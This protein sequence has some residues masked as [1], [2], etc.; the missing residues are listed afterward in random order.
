MDWAKLF[1]G[2][3]HMTLDEFKAAL[4][5]SG[6]KL[7]D[8]N[9]GEYVGKAKFDDQVKRHKKAL[10]DVTAERDKLK[11]AVDEADTDDGDE[12]AKQLKDMQD[13]LDATAKDIEAEKAKSLRL[14][15]EKVVSAKVKDARFARLAMIDAVAGMDD[16][17]DFEISLEDVL[18]ANPDYAPAED[19]DDDEPVPTVRTGDPVK[20]KPKQQEKMLDSFAET[21]GVEADD[22]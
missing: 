19:D 15:R 1:D 8:L 7:A 22:E 20:G 3:E 11:K 10:G 12:L 5:K 14:E 16:D 2:K 21:L 6:A 18:K 17:K 9:D 13:K 4:D